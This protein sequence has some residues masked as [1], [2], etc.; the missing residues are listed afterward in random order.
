MHIF[1]FVGGRMGGDDRRCRLQTLW[2][3]LVEKVL[4]VAQLPL[5][6][7]VALIALPPVKPVQAEACLTKHQE[8]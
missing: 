5:E 7:I 4:Q 8:P 1:T 6:I 2:Q 3:A